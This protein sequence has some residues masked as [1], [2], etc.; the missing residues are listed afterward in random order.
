MPKMLKGCRSDADQTGRGKSFA[1]L[2]IA[3]VST[4]TRVTRA[5][6]LMTLFL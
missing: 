3:C 6:R 2:T 4:L 5:S 1:A